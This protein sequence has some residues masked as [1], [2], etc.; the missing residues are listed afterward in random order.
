MA[1]VD[2]GDFQQLLAAWTAT[3]YMLANSDIDFRNIPA[4]P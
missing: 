1:I 2:R 3:V 4:P